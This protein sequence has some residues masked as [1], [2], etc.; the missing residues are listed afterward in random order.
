[1]TDRGMR[2]LRDNYDQ[3]L[4]DRAYAEI[5]VP[6]F[7]DINEREP[8]QA[9]ANRLQAKEANAQPETHLILSGEALDDPIKAELDG[10]VIVEL[11]GRSG[12]SL[13]TYL[14]TA[15]SARGRGIGKNLLWQARQL[16]QRRNRRDSMVLAEVHN[17]ELIDCESDIMD[18]FKRL[19]IFTALGARII[20][21]RYV[22]PALS[23]HSHKVS[24]LVLL[25]F[26]QSEE[27]LDPQRLIN[28]FEEFYQALGISDPWQDP[29]FIL[30]WH[31]L[32][33][34]I[35]TDHPLDSSWTDLSRKTGCPFARIGAATQPHAALPIRN[36]FSH[37]AISLHYPLRRSID[38]ISFNHDLESSSIFSSFERDL[39]AHAFRDQGVLKTIP[40][41]FKELRIR[42]EFPAILVYQSEGVVSRLLFASGKR[43]IDFNCRAACS[44]LQPSG[45]QSRAHLIEQS[46]HSV[47]HAILSSSIDLSAEN[48][49]VLTEYELIQLCKLWEG[50]EGVGFSEQYPIRSQLRF[51]LYG[52]HDWEKVSPLHLLSK[53]FWTKLLV[54]ACQGSSRLMSEFPFPEVCSST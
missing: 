48:E 34:L 4:M 41:D 37:W 45:G 28:F 30:M 3:V 43:L 8:K 22:Q 13:V 40:L 32:V 52:S 21:I 7:S 16:T 35:T 12:L 31:D 15:P 50:G 53:R 23:E 47:L 17:P 18:P 25:V 24:S 26:G 10:L 20:P 46:E 27:G 51:R 19:K 11:Y 36:E 14:A 2:N 33:A 54:I 29:D 42:I 9:I 5:M 49:D 38:G 1:M 39:L 6:I 44:F